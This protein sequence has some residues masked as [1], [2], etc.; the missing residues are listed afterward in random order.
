MPIMRLGNV[1]SFQTQV[2]GYCSTLRLLFGKFHIAVAVVVCLTSLL[3]FG[4]G[5]GHRSRQRTKNSP[6]QT[7]EIWIS[8]NNN[9]ARRSAQPHH[10][11]SLY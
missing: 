3:L 1:P 8:N 7:C 9:G 11:I 4:G 2:Q 10:S 6:V 5:G